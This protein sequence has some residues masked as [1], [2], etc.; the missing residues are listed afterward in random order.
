MKASVRAVLLAC[1]FAASS[2]HSASPGKTSQAPAAVTTASALVRTPTPEATTAIYAALDY[3]KPGQ[4][5]LGALAARQIRGVLREVKPCQRRLL[6]YI[7]DE[8]NGQGVDLFFAVQSK[9]SW[10]SGPHIFGSHNEVY[11]QNEG[12]VIATMQ[13]VT[14]RQ[15]IEDRACSS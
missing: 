14:D 11:Y 6:R 2:C 3:G 15:A 8:A 7:V 5:R 4:P 10:F 1:A 13:T 9:G 12:Q